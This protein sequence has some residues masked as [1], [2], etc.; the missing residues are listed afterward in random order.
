ML[1]PASQIDSGAKMK[2]TNVAKCV[3][4]VAAIA[5]LPLALEG[6]SDAYA[7]SVEPAG[8]EHFDLSLTTDSTGQGTPSSALPTSQGLY[9][10]DSYTSDC[11]KF[12]FTLT[13]AAGPDAGIKM[14]FPAQTS[15]TFKAWLQPG[16][17]L[18][19]SNWYGEA[20]TVRL[21]GELVPGTVTHLQ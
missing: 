7:Q 11:T 18:S 5:C 17:Q 4:G 9:Q 21:S 10:I 16:D 2:L 20:C 6:C 12:F 8:P 3:A 14:N 13:V 19:A 15:A 1:A